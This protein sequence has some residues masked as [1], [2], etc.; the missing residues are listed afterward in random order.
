MT[1]ADA[2]NKVTELSDYSV[3][4]IWGVLGQKI[5][6]LHVVRKKMNYPDL[7]RAVVET[8]HLF[9]VTTILIEDMA[10]GT[11]LI[12]DQQGEGGAS[13]IAIKPVGEKAVRMDNQTG[14]LEAGRVYL[15]EYAHW[16]DEYLHEL[17]AFPNGRHFDQVDSTSQAL[18][19]ITKSNSA[20]AWVSE[21]EAQQ[22]EA[23]G[24]VRLE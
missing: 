1:G 20:T 8:A 16:L 19:W 9:E 15:P 4:T 24:W 21:A 12:Q 10:S 13:V 2:A 23:R 7:K 11:Q 22:L 6:L 5:Y 3:F 17:T 14:V 18:M